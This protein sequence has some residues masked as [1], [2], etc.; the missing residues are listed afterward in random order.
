MYGYQGWFNCSG[1]GA[2]NGWNHYENDGSFKDGYCHIDFWPDVS[3]YTKKYSTPFK[4]S[5]GSTAYVFSSYDAQTVDVHFK[6]MR[7]YNQDGAFMQRFTHSIRSST[8]KNHYMKVFDNAVLAANKYDRALSIR[9]DITD[10]DRDDY[11]DLLADLDELNS[12]YNFFSRTGSKTF[13]HHNGKPLIAIGGIGWEDDGVDISDRGYLREAQYI[14]DG[15]RS[16]GYSIMMRVPAHWRITGGQFVTSATNQAKFYTQ[17]KRCDI[18]MPWHVGAYSEENYLGTWPNRIK[19]DIAWC[20]TNALDY[21][22]VVYPG[23][24]RYN[25]SGRTDTNSFRARNKG[26][27]YW[28]QV[29]RSMSMGAEMM[30]LAQFDE[31]DEG[32]QFF[33]CVRPAPSASLSKFKTYES[34]VQNDHYLWLAGESGRML[35]K[36]KAYTTILPIRGETNPPTPIACR[37]VTPTG[38]VTVSSGASLYVNVSA[39]DADGVV[40]VKLYNGTV[41][42]SS[43]ASEPYE[44]NLTNIVSSL[45]LTAK[46]YD[47]L[48]NITVSDNTIIVTVPGSTTTVPS[49]INQTKSAATT[50]ITGA[51]LVVGTVTSNYSSTVAA[52][53]VIS[54]NPVGGTVV[55]RGTSVALT[56]SLGTAPVTTTVPS[57]INQTLSAATAS[58]TGAGL[59]VGTVTSNY[60]STVAAGNVISQTPVGGTTVNRGSSVDLAVSRGPSTGT[61]V[62][63]YS[64]GVHDGYVDESSETSNVGG[65]NN[66]TLTTGTGLRV[67]DTGAKKQRKSIVSFDTSTLPDTAVV[68]AATLK[69]K[70][71]GGLGVP[72]GFGNLTVDIKNVSVGF[73]TSLN[74]ENMDFEY[75]ASKSDVGTLSYPAA[76]NAWAIAALNTNGTARI[77]KTNHTQFRIRF[78]TD[79]D[80][81]SADDYLGFYSGENATAADRPILE[82]TYQ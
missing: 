27:F 66:A 35:R 62:T 73:G 26:S 75:A 16:R 59:V 37:I 33:K 74:L 29:S 22:P 64:I 60:S 15:L 63:F 52:G 56:V 49:V 34:D 81:D 71:G 76:T 30:F 10:C 32:T 1:D 57:V 43:D 77:A 18:V 82:V 12:K 14:I 68:T 67:G 42:V 72:S 55:N 80:N 41:E 11:K 25:L 19:D 46:A 31:V 61:T 48:G 51:G 8:T 5:G 47:R 2:N 13:L 54:Q 3:E 40:R 7:D 24:S 23:F 21:V 50:S 44:F 39:C 28:K 69:L 53:N 6:W 58:I 78:A 36:E 45:V 79:D 9:Y 70:R 65:T 4:F 20:K 17:L 38:N